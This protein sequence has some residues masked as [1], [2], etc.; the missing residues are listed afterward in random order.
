MLGLIPFLK[1]FCYIAKHMF[2]DFQPPN[3]AQR[4]FVSNLA[5]AACIAWASPIYMF[6]TNLHLHTIKLS[7]EYV[8]F[9]A[10]S[11]ITV[12]FFFVI[13]FSFLRAVKD[14]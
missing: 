7:L 9:L 2:E 12:L 10:S 8:L 11:L 6:L 3:A 1:I 4:K 14:D 13:G 5:I